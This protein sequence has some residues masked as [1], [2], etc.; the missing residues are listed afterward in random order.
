[1]SRKKTHYS[2]Q[3]KLDAINYRKEHPVL[4]HVECDKNLLFYFVLYLNTEPII[5]WY[6]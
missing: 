1:M 6:H 5:Y 2:K 4:T 3:F